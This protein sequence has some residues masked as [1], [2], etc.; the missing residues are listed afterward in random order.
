MSNILPLKL[1]T[2]ILLIFSFLFILS[3]KKENPVIKKDYSVYQAGFEFN[4]SLD[5]AVYWKNDT[6]F[7]LSIQNS[8]AYDIS[9]ASNKVYVVGYEGQT[10]RYPVLWTDGLKNVLSGNQGVATSIFIAGTDIY[11]C[12][13]EESTLGSIAVFWKNGVKTQLA[14]PPSY[15]SS[16]F[17][18]GNDVYISGGANGNICV[19]KNSNSLPMLASNGIPSS[20]SLFVSNS[21]F[22]C[23]GNDFVNNTRS[24]YLWTNGMN[25]NLFSADQSVKLNSI[26]CIGSDIFIAGQDQNGPCYW[27]NRSRV[28]LGVANNRGVAYDICV[29]ENDIYVTGIESINNTPNKPV[30]WKNGTSRTLMSTKTYSYPYS[31]FVYNK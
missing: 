4:G 8:R 30:C 18:S 21:N 20:N 7:Q 22:Y 3:C 26:Y 16:V 9:V 29:I 11:I 23:I 2:Q 19:W 31:I 6:I 12:G 27:K 13:S 1:G 25:R 14:S 24:E 15:A 5:N 17:V 28:Q 10:I